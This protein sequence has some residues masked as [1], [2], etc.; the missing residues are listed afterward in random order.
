[1][2]EDQSFQGQVV[3]L[4]LLQ[5]SLAPNPLH[6]KLLT[7]LQTFQ[8]R[9]TLPPT[10]P[11]QLIDTDL[12][13]NQNALFC[14]GNSPEF[15]HFS[16]MCTSNCGDLRHW[17]FQFPTKSFMATA[18]PGHAFWHSSKRSGMFP[19]NIA[20]VCVLLFALICGL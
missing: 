6:S 8:N 16:F 1:M 2:L 12:D 15:A 14:L 18:C 7:V 20:V 19:H 5:N 17:S 9:G 11:R 13:T 10:F 3:R 4:S